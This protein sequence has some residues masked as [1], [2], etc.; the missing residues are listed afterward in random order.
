MGGTEP[1]GVREGRPSD[2]RHTVGTDRHRGFQAIRRPIFRNR[3][4]HPH[5][6]PLLTLA[7]YG[8]LSLVSGNYLMA[9]EQA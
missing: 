7:I 8:H 6:G 5:R 9:D 2:L 4:R 3:K 1:F